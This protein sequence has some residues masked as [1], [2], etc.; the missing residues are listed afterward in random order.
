MKTR[1]I[2]SSPAKKYHFVLLEV[3]AA[4]WPE[5]LLHFVVKADDRKLFQSFTP[6]QQIVLQELDDEEGIWYDVAKLS[7]ASQL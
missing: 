3:E 6:D 1:I 7:D 5:A 4:T 2:I